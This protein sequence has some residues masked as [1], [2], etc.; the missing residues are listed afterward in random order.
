MLSWGRV[1][2]ALQPLVLKYWLNGRSGKSIETSV[3]GLHLQVLPSVF[4]PK[5][6]GSSAILARF[7]STLPL[8]GKSF[9][10][11][12]CGSGI[13]S[14]CAARAG[15]IVTAVD[16]NPAAV[17]CTL[18][19]AARHGL[20]VHAH[21]GDLFTPL[22]GA[23]FDVIAWNPPFLPGNPKSPA[24]AAFYGG[25]DFELIR[26]FAA[27]VRANLKPGGGVYTILSA[28]IPIERIEDVFRSQQFTVNRILSTRWGL[29][30]TMVIL[31]AR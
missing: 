25:P 7:V 24:E 1:R 16:I 2:R 27:S 20:Q 14:L 30:E 9:L 3:E 6:F 26:R 15:A 28:D 23:R 8:D 18:L 13:V 5:Y 4:H 10:E 19:N 31:C 11:I 22:N 29:G 17:K 21:A 12:G